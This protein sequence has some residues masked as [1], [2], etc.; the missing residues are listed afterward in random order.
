MDTLPPKRFWAGIVQ[1]S[2]KRIGGPTADFAANG[3]FSLSDLNCQHV[4]ST[5]PLQRL[6]KLSAL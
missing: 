5:M 1:F 2:H 4:A 6:G 3:E